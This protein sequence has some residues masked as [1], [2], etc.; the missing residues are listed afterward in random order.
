[1][2]ESQHRS[3][4]QEARYMMQQH[5]HYAHK[6][7]SKHFTR[8]PKL[9]RGAAGE[10]INIRYT[11]RAPFQIIYKWTAHWFHSC[12]CNLADKRN[13]EHGTRND[14]KRNTDGR[15]LSTSYVWPVPLPDNNVQWHS[16]VCPIARN[17]VWSH[18]LQTGQCKD[19]R[20]WAVKLDIIWHY[21]D[22]GSFMKKCP[23]ML[24]NIGPIK[25]YFPTPDIA[26]FFNL[27]YPI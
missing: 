20:I 13:T 9:E 23:I 27:T 8:P 14:G 1:M 5:K 22:K 25:G 3:R 10:K 4:S 7:N 2:L 11:T 6:Q 24:G 17:L 21:L 19:Q 26:Y 12:H 18:E 15:T 16:T